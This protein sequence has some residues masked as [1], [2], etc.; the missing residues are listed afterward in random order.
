[1][2]VKFYLDLKGYRTLFLSFGVKQKLH[3]NPEDVA[4]FREIYLKNQQNTPVSEWKEKATTLPLTHDRS[5]S[6]YKS[7]FDRSQSNKIMDGHETP[8][9][10][11]RDIKGMENLILRAE[12]ADISK[13]IK[14]VDKEAM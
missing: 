9:I 6:N 3:K 4:R 2:R 13:E 11:R 7:G 14:M 5:K 1:M 12:K 8:T 10:Q